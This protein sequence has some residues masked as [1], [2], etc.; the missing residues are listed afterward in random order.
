MVHGYNPI[1]NIQYRGRIAVAAA[2]VAFGFLL[3]MAATAAPTMPSAASPSTPAGPV[4]SAPPGYVQLS[5]G[6]MEDLPPAAIVKASGYDSSVVDTVTS[7]TVDQLW[8]QTDVYWHQG[9]YP[10]I[11]ALDKLIVQL[12]PH[13]MEPYSIGGWLMES[14]GNYADA[15]A[16]YRLGVANNPKDSYLYY[17]LAAFY[18][19]TQKDY[20]SAANIMQVGVTMKGNDVNDWRMYAHAL[21]KS[22]HIDDAIATWQAIIKRFPNAAA[23]DINLARLQKIKKAQANPT[24]N[25]EISL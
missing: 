19:N 22:K 7:D 24:T 16:F 14:M 8:A 2:C 11:I 17:Q 13:F 4:G 9:D 3:S 23:A 25:G 6:L 12:D 1:M 20:Q 5:P 15:E 10:R 21:E 18:F